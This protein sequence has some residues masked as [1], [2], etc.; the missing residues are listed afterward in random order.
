MARADFAFH[1]FAERNDIAV[2][3]DAHFIGFGDAVGFI[4]GGIAG[5]GTG[6]DVVDLRRR[7]LEAVGFDTEEIAF[8]LERVQQR[9][10]MRLYGRFA[11]SD[12]DIARGVGF[13]TA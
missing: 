4:F 1:V 8:R 13:Q 3:H 12:D 7:G 11:A 6:G 10:E 5:F 9:I 2:R